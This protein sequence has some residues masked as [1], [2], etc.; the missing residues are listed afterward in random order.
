MGQARQAADSR[1]GTAGDEYAWLRPQEAGVLLF[2]H[3]QPGAR[4][5]GVCG[6]HGG[7]LRLAIAAPPVDGR[8]NEALAAWIAGTLGVPRR[9]VRIAAGE[10]SRDKTVRIDG[11]TAA[12]VARAMSS[13]P[14]KLE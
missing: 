3:L 4:R 7:R 10:R 5:N 14:A 8:A 13:S 2:V 11:V 6:T 12:E 1:T 9:Q